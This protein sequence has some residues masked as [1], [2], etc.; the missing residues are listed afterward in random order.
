MAIKKPNYT[1]IPNDILDE[2]MNQLSGAE[3]KILMAIARKTFGWQKKK[4]KISIN[5]LIELTGLSKRNII[6]SLRKLQFLKIIFIEGDERNIKNFGIIIDEE[7]V[8]DDIKSGAE[9]APD[10][11]KAGAIIA[12]AGA[13]IAPDKA[14]S[15]AI[16]TPTKESNIKKTNTKE[17]E[18]E[19]FIVTKNIFYAI[20]AELNNGETPDFTADDFGM[21][22]TTVRRAIKTR[23]DPEKLISEKLEALKQKCLAD[24]QR[25]FWTFTPRKLIWGW[26]DLVL[27]K[28]ENI[29]MSFLNNI[30]FGDRQ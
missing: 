22:K 6:D 14:K 8:A 1:Q 18:T 26:N 24:V 17:K 19:L 9:I 29:D 23:Y 21:I 4:D 27:E 13:I 30:N 25:K 12:P 20:Y 10:N 11:I 15:G 5:Q 7:T 2:W 28:R 3:F 16:I